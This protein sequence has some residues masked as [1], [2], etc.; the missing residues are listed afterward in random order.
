MQSE[1][2]LLFLWLLFEEA[3]LILAFLI[4]F[5]SFSCL[6]YEVLPRDYLF[7]IFGLGIGAK[8]LL[9]ILLEVA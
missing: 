5:I 2:L 6:K 3:L 9:L 4:A 8:T 7:Y 1:S